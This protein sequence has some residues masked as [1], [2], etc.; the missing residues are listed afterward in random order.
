MNDARS[1]ILVKCLDVVQAICENDGEKIA[2]KSIFELLSLK[3]YCKQHSK[4]KEQQKEKKAA[5][6]S[7]MAVESCFSVTR[8]DPNSTS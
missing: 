2:T 1:C 6:T 5:Q 8:R 7:N 4:S 3:V